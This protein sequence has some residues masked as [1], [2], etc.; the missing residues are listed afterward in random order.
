MKIYCHS[1]SN[2]E[3]VL[4]KAPIILGGAVA[5]TTIAGSILY[6][7]KILNEIEKIQL[8]DKNEE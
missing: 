2:L 8:F 3:K 5:L 7:K 1:E 6:G 4:K